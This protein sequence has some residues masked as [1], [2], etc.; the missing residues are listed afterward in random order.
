MGESVKGNLQW[1]ENLAI[2]GDAGPL[3]LGTLGGA[4]STAAVFTVAAWGRYWLP[5]AAYP[6]H[7][8]G[9][10]P[11]RSSIDGRPL[12]DPTVGAVID[13]IAALLTQIWV[14]RAA[15]DRYGAAGRGRRGVGSFSG[16]PRRARWEPRLGHDAIALLP[17]S[18]GDRVQVP[19]I[20]ALE[21]GVVEVIMLG[22]TI[23]RTGDNRRIVVP[24]SAMANQVT[25]TL[26]P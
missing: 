22:Y 11:R 16:W 14:S 19:P 24:N 26:R 2:R 4:I 18:G 13:V 9:G 3:M 5:K 23:L 20:G 6:C 10:P 15:G 21:T 1:G 25:V 8:R 7:G 17:V 12:R